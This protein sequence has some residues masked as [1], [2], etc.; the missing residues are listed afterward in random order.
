[1]EAFGVIVAV[2]VVRFVDASAAAV[3][4]VDVAI[5]VPALVVC[6]VLLFLWY[7]L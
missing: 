4:F 7:G 2:V 5:I 1:M 6:A 3:L